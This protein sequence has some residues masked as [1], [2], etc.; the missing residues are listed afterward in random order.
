VGGTTGVGGTGMGAGGAGWAGSTGGNSPNCAGG[1]CGNVHW[2]Q[3]L[4]SL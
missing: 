1:H 4:C 3:L 2:L